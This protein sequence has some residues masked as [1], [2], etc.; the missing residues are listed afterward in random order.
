MQIFLLNIYLCQQLGTNEM[1]SIYSI[2]IDVGIYAI[3]RLKNDST[4]FYVI[5]RKFIHVVR[6][7]FL[8]R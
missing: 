1:T 6:S 8:T 7:R 2:K 3:N 4:D 5:F